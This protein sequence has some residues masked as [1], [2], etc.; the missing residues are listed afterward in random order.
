VIEKNLRHY[1]VKTFQKF[2]IPPTFWDPGGIFPHPDIC[3]LSHPTTTR[4]PFGQQVHHSPREPHR[5]DGD[6]EKRMPV[7]SMPIL[8]FVIVVLSETHPLPAL[9]HGFSESHISLNVSPF[10][11]PARPSMDD[12]NRHQ[13][14]NR[15]APCS[16]SARDFRTQRNQFPACKRDVITG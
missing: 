5:Q 9:K 14:T 3:S 11:R 13:T 10:C 4:L 12:E 15:D 1:V 2:S 8:V 6:E 16:A 7:P